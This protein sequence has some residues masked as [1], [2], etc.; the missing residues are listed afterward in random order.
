[1]CL[2]SEIFLLGGACLTVSL[3]VLCSHQLFSTS[4]HMIFPLPSVLISRYC[5]TQTTSPSYVR[6]LI[7]TQPRLPYS[8]TFCSSNSGLTPTSS[9]PHPKNPLSHCSLPTQ[10]NMTTTLISGYITPFFLWINILRSSESASILYS[11]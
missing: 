1:M 6:Q 2:A 3:R 4:T 11:P 10:E 9:L 7:F 8:S 5:R